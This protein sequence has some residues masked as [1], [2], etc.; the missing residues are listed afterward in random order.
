[1]TIKRSQL[2]RAFDLSNVAFMVVLIILMIVPLLHVLNIS[3]SSAMETNKGGIFL[4]PRDFSVLSYQV[5][6]AEPNLVTS[7]ANTIAY[8][9]GRTI[10]TLIFSSMLAYVVAIPEFVFRK[11]ITV[12]LTITMF[13]SGGLIP[14]FLVVRGLGLYNTFWAM[15]L[16]GCVGCINVILF[17]TFFRANAMTL[18]EAAIIDGAGDFHIYLR[19]V[20]PL[21][22]AIF[23]TI[24]LFTAVSQWN[25]WFD[26]MVYLKDD[27]RYPY[28]MILQ[29]VLDSVDNT[30]RRTNPTMQDLYTKQ[31]FNARN[32]Q[33][34]AIVVGMVPILCTYPFVQKYF[35]KG[36]FVGSLKE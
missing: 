30:L 35:V 29:R 19:I 11:L 21:S 13:V 33:M 17:R 26:A 25:S 10:V 5:I 3:L 6:F 4:Y 18:R 27:S 8:T 31:K 36:V 1:M 2:E 9:L 14:S 12:M 28:Q 23:A 20:M 32:I 22:T 15:V 34:A 24:G 7:Y 16:P